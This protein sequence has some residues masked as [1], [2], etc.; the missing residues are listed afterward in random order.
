LETNQKNTFE[1]ISKKLRLKQAGSITFPVL[2][3]YDE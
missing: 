2:W 1:N 3:Y